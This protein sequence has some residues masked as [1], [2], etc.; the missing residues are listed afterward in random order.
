MAS[1]FAFFDKLSG[2]S[3]QSLLTYS[4]VCGGQ[5][6]GAER[7]G[8][9]YDQEVRWFAFRVMFFVVDA[10]SEHMFCCKWWW[11][12]MEKVLVCTCDPK[13][14]AQMIPWLFAVMPFLGRVAFQGHGS[15]PENEHQC[16]GLLSGWPQWSFWWHPCLCREWG[17]VCLSLG[18]RLKKRHLERIG[19]PPKRWDVTML[20]C[21]DVLLP[22]AL[23]LEMLNLGIELG[24]IGEL[25]ERYAS[26]KWV[27]VVTCTSLV[28]P[29]SGP[30]VTIRS[31]NP[32]QPRTT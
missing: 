18:H 1:S 17:R 23:R 21:L 11:K 24:R 5:P 12:K 8:V 3:R 20:R 10:W 2:A 29:L 16:G 22:V 19:C 6:D 15:L 14:C 31:S 32:L 27:N 13:I 4:I 26:I 9:E 25:Q 7:L 30:K 28:R